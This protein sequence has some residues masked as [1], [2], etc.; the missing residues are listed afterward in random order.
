MVSNC[1]EQSVKKIAPYTLQ[2][3]CDLGIIVHKANHKNGRMYDYDIYKENRPATPK[4]VVNVFDLGYL[5]IEKDFPQQLSSL[6]S[7]RRE[8]LNHHMKK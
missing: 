3:K 4:E 5:G 2:K 7:K 6:S 8:T 1:P